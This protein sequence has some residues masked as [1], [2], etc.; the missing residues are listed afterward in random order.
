M[1]TSGRSD[2][3]TL[4]SSVLIWVIVLSSVRGVDIGAS[5]SL[6]FFDFVGGVA[7]A[8][9]TPPMSAMVELGLMPYAETSRVKSER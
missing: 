1:S 3:R 5:E 6:D 7:P 8:G 2:V 9:S 4:S